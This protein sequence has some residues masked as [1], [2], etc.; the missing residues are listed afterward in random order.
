MVKAVTRT[1]FVADNGEEFPTEGGAIYAEARA[2]FEE[3]LHKN[4]AFGQIAEDDVCSFLLNNRDAVRE[5]LDAYDKWIVMP[6]PQHKPVS[7]QLHT[8]DMD[9]G[10]NGR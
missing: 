4:C 6:R 1:V 5:W 7:P 3:L 2:K 9:E 10:R 8:P